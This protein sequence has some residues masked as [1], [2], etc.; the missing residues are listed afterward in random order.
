[1]ANFKR[2]AG[3]MA[4][5]SDKLNDNGIVTTP[6]KAYWPNDMGLYNMGGNVSEWVMDVYRPLSFEDVEDLNP[7]RG[8]VFKAKELDA[9][10]IPVDKDSLGR[11]IYKTLTRIQTA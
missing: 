1:M 4:G 8:N 3:D 10:R 6:V 9:D 5:I 11:M 2:D 7:F